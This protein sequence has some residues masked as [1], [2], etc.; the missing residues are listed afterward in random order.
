MRT[1]LSSPKSQQTEDVGGYEIDMA[2]FLSPRLLTDARA[3]QIVFLGKRLSFDLISFDLEI[4]KERVEIGIDVC[5]E[6]WISE[7]TARFASPDDFLFWGHHVFLI[8]GTR[9]V[10]TPVYRTYA[11]QALEFPDIEINARLESP[12]TVKLTI[13][14]REG[15]QN[16]G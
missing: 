4:Q 2:Q 16:E 14:G 11:V 3:F 7:L 9:R 13:L 6:R 10:R 12:P 1:L 15:G 5:E 8:N